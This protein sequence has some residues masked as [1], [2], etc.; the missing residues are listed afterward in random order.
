M[1]R[2]KTKMLENC[3]LAR[4]PPV[5]IS[6]DENLVYYAG[7]RSGLKKRMPKKTGEGILYYTLAT[8]NKGY[9]GYKEEIREETKE[10][11]EGKI[12]R[13]ADPVCGGYVL[14]YIMEPGR[15]YAVGTTATSKVFGAMMLLIFSCGT[16]LRYKDIRVVTDSAYGVLEGMALMSLW[17][18]AWVTSLRIAQRRGFLGVKQ[19][20]DAGKVQKN[21]KPKSKNDEG[22]SMKK[23]IAAWEKKVAS[24]QKGSYWMWKTSLQ[25]MKDVYTTVY[26]TAI[27]DAKIC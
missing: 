3:K 7:F 13:R 10:G 21:K 17:E 23:D 18:I 24:V 27:K 14:N 5:K 9:E 15:R 12:I 1:C 6:A 2:L 19:I 26:L 8:S 25:I 4:E 11:D 22:R 20:E 16:Y